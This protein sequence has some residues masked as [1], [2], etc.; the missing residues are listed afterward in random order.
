MVTNST[1]LYYLLQPALNVENE[2]LANDGV[3]L[4]NY[5]KFRL[6]GCQHTAA[7]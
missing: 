7:C 2:I 1:A 3:I 5:Q 4:M 6:P